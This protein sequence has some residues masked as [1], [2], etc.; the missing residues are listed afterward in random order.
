M[1]RFSSYR[2]CKIIA[3]VCCLSLPAFADWD[4]EESADF[5]LNTVPEPAAAL[6]V[7]GFALYVWRSRRHSHS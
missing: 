5:T 1:T 2:C 6:A 7:A 3:L 4:S